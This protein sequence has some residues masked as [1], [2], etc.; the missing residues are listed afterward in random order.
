MLYQSSETVPEFYLST[1]KINTKKVWI[2]GLKKRLVCKAVTN[3]ENI[4]IIFADF[5]KLISSSFKRPND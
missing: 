1:T 3:F 2:W 5:D 4:I